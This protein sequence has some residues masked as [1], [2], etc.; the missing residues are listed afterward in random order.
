[1]VFEGLPDAPELVV[2]LDVVVL[3]V[4]AEFAQGCHA[5]HPV[6]FLDSKVVLPLPAA[7]VPAVQF[8]ALGR[9]SAG[10]LVAVLPAPFDLISAA[11]IGKKQEIRLV[12]VLPERID[13]L[14]PVEAFTDL[15]LVRL[16]ES[17]AVGDVVFHGG[18]VAHEAQG[19]LREEAEVINER[20]F[21]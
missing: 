10:D 2:Y 16:R 14:K 15:Q 19:V 12:Q 21:I 1:M 5:L 3:V 11:R 9:A 17:L 18:A 8:Q 6:R 13:P 7:A 20:F 4:R